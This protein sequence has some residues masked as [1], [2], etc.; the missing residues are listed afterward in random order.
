MLTDIATGWT[1]CAV[2]VQTLLSTL[3]TELRKQPAHRTSRSGFMNETLKDSR[4]AVNIVFTRCR[5]YPKNG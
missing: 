3:L 2:R 4:D 5:P 1:E